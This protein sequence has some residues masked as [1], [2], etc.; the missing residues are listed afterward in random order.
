LSEFIQL[1]NNKDN[2]LEAVLL[3]NERKKVPKRQSM[4]KSYAK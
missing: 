4:K 2:S 3:E 1:I